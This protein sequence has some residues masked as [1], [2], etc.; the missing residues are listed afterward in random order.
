LKKHELEYLQA[1]NLFVKRKEVELKELIDEIT[2]R[3]GDKLTN[4]SKIKRLELNEH[5]MKQ[6]FIDQATQ[7]S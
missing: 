1:Y 2:N 3:L 4:D 5:V 6:K 7:I